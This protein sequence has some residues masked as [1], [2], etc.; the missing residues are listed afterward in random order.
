MAPRRTGVLLAPLLLVTLGAVSC[1]PVSPTES[2]AGPQVRTVSLSPTAATL[3][4]GDTLALTATV[5]AETGADQSLTWSS[6]KAQVATVDQSG[7]VTA[8]GSG[9][10]TITATSK[11]TPT[12]SGTMSITVNAAV[13]VSSLLGIFNI[14]A[15]KITDTGCNFAT[16]FVG[17]VSLSGNKDGTALTIRLIEQLTRIYNG[18]MQASGS[19]SGTGSGNL[20]G[21]NY[22]GTV[23]GAV[24]SGGATITGQETL[25]FT[26]GCPGRMVVYS[27]AGAK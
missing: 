15:T 9:A 13:D 10:A 17:Q 4:A 2:T 19:Y 3:A 14:S 6:S 11:T 21:F 12:V 23:A 22:N 5:T 16:S 7:K 27:F 26:T 8:V 1:K 25:N 24:G 20:G 18:T